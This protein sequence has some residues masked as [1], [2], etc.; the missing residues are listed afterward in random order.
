MFP[1]LGLLQI[2]FVTTHPHERVRSSM[3]VRFID[4]FH[5]APRR[6]EDFVAGEDMSAASE[7]GTGLRTHVA[8]DCAAA[9]TVKELSDLYSFDV[10]HLV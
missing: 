1:Q 8:L 2:V 4:F 5:V 7:G 6:D 9:L 3:S 10:H